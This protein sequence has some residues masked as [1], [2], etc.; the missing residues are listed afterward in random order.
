MKFAFFNSGSYYLFDPKKLVFEPKGGN[1]KRSLLDIHKELVTFN[2][3]PSCF[4]LDG[5]GKPL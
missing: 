4:I 1:N 3:S 5:N 2:S